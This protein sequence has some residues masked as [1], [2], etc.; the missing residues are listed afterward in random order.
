LTGRSANREISRSER[1]CCI[2]A[3]N[4]SQNCAVAGAAEKISKP[5]DAKNDI[6]NDDL[7]GTVLLRKRSNLEGL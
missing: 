3:S 7:I 6:R 1:P 4:D 5:S 2:G